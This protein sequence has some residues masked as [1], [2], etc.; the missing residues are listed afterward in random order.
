MSYEREVFIAVQAAQRILATT[1]P[2]LVADGKWGTFT[3]AAYARADA[4]QRD[5]VDLVL[6]KMVNLR[7]SEL[8][9]RRAAQK[10]S[11]GSSVATGSVDDALTYASNESGV[12]KF[13]LAGFAKIESGNNPLAV[14][15]N[16]RGLMQMQ[17]RA[18][19]HA[20]QMLPSL[21][22]YDQVFNAVQNARAGAQYIK[23]NQ[24]ALQSLGYSGPLTPAVLYMAHQQGATGFVELWKLATGKS[25]VRKYVTT[26]ALRRNPPQ[27]GKGVTTDPREFLTRWLAVAEREMA[28]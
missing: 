23:V 9:A 17:P 21:P 11:T 27:D 20:Q 3:H 15:G 13:I 22:D 18:W 4:K 8:I 28:V 7:P 25:T 16:S 6:R 1:Q 24:R 5:E 19:K 14:N 2:E 12:P 10:V 26:E